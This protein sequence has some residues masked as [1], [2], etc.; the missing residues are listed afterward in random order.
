M[1]FGA[2]SLRQEVSF[3]F[4]WLFYD[5]VVGVASGVQARAVDTMNVGTRTVMQIEVTAT[6]TAPLPSGIALYGIRFAIRPSLA[7]RTT[8]ITG[9]LRQALDAEGRSARLQEGT[10][11][12]V[13]IIVPT[14]T[15]SPSSTPTVSPASV[16]SRTATSSPTSTPTPRPE[17]LDG[18]GSV[19]VRDLEFL[20]AALFSTPEVGSRANLNR[21]HGVSAADIPEF[22]RRVSGLR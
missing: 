13:E 5:G 8:E 7:S 16:P 2:R 11:G 9:V 22:Y 12:L 4:A 21:D 14:H 20:L 15:P 19:D 1:G 3:E 17:D 10:P 18:D 6:G